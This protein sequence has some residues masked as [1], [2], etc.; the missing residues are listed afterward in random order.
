MLFSE[1]LENLLK[2]MNAENEEGTPW[3]LLTHSHSLEQ[4][5]TLRYTGILQTH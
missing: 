4:I 3:I 2:F 5:T 1:S